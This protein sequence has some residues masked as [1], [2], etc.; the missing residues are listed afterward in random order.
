[1]EISVALR[2]QFCSP[3]EGSAWCWRGRQ[4]DVRPVLSPENY[5][6]AISMV[7]SFCPS[8]EG[9]SALP[10]T[11]PNSLS[12]CLASDFSVFVRWRRLYSILTSSLS[13]LCDGKLMAAN[14]LLSVLLLWRNYH[15]C[16]NF[17]VARRTRIAEVGERQ[18][19]RRG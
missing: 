17:D 18:F 14:C 19:R 16:L 4:W 7:I 11:A 6:S 12:L 8:F 3:G 13:S 5:C 2:H 9:P 15:E 10:I 1:M